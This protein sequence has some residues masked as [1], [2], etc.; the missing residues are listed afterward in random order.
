M[1]HF[2]LEDLGGLKQLIPAGKQIL[3]K[4]NLFVAKTNDNSTPT[5]SPE[6]NRYW[7][8]TKN[9]NEIIAEDY[10]PKEFLKG[11]VYLEI[12]ENNI[13]YIQKE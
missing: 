4:P 12:D 6:K 10:A 9:N 5:N 3:I 2:T 13:Q 7:I 8:R 1:I 11:K